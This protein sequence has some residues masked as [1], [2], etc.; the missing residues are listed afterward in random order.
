MAQPNNKSNPIQSN[1]IRVGLGWKKK[2]K[3]N[4]TQLSL[5]VLG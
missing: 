5:I 2:S 3:S 1:S 4:P